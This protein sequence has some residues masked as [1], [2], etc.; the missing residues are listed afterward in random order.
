MSHEMRFRSSTPEWIRKCPRP[1]VVV[2]LSVLRSL[3][4]G[5]GIPGLFTA[6]IPDRTV[7]ELIGSADP[8]RSIAKLDGILCHPHSRGRLLLGRYWNNIEEEEVRPED[9][10]SGSI[11]AI[12]PALSSQIRELQ[13]TGSILGDAESLTP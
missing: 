10:W 11:A 1:W 2:D 8:K 3:P 13:A 9:V 4:K 12:D 7:A 5:S 6:I